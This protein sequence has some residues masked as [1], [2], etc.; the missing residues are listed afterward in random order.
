DGDR[1]LIRVSGAAGDP[2]GGL[3]LD[4]TLRHPADMERDRALSFNETRPGVYEASVPGLSDGRWRLV[5][6]AEGEIPFSVERELWR[7]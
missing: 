1:V 6:E 7:R 3:V 4:G 5:V 2:V